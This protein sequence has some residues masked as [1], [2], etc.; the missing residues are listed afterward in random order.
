MGGRW[1]LAGFHLR[2][3]L[4][5][6]LIIHLLA[7][8]C[9]SINLEVESDP[10]GALANWNP[11][12][13]N[14][15]NWTG[16]HCIDGKV[17]SILLPKMVLSGRYDMEFTTNSKW[18]T[19]EAHLQEPK[20]IFSARNFGTRAWKAEPLENSLKQQAAE[21]VNGNSGIDSLLDPALKSHEDEELRIICEVI[22]E[23]VDPDLSKRPT[24]KEVAS[25]LSEVISI[26][27]EAATPRLC[28]LW[29]A[30]LEILSV[31]AT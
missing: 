29:W 24:M 8:G 31:E 6:V 18:S 30:E 20:R 28:P 7:D 12:D 22:Q 21:Y 10:Y 27:P 4:C 26:T 3:V 5:M 25:K 11:R 13:N 16:V 1:K 23:C 19:N 14:P 9:L 17:D 2:K 15:C